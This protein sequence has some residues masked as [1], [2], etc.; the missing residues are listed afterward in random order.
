MDE[1]LFGFL[2]AWIAVA[3]RLDAASARELA[4]MHS[5]RLGAGLGLQWLDRSIAY[6]ASVSFASTAGWFRASD[7][8]LRSA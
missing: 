1:S 8:A 3:L 5:R 2:L 4:G 6:N 7:T